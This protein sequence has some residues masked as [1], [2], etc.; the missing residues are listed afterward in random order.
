MEGLRINRWLA[1]TLY[2][3]CL[4]CPGTF[5]PRIMATRDWFSLAASTDAVTW[6]S[7]EFTGLLANLANLKSRL[8]SHI[9]A[10][11]TFPCQY[12]CSHRRS[13][14][15]PSGPLYKLVAPTS[16]REYCYEDRSSATNVQRMASQCKLPCILYLNIVVT[17]YEGSPK[18]MEDYLGK[19][20]T[21]LFEDGLAVDNSAEHL[22]I[23]LL[24]GFEYLT[25]ETTHRAH[26]T[27]RMASVI[28]KLEVGLQH[29]IH[30]VLLGA[31]VPHKVDAESGSRL[32]GG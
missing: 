15:T 23:K 7:A 4:V 9:K 14:F 10:G 21:C 6:P 11:C 25:A 26:Q 1:A 31:L 17:E 19:L 28:H 12:S 13:V 16:L 22:L 20:R 18:L 8:S 3:N 2:W 29:R 24:I 32:R 27:I 5:D 30:T